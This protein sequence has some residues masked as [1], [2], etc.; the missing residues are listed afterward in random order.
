VNATI[1]WRAVS[2]LIETSCSAPAVSVAIG[3]SMTTCLPAR[4][5]LAAMATCEAF[6]VQMCTTSMSGSSSRPS[7][8]AVDRGTPS[9]AAFAAVRFESVPASATTSAYPVRRIAST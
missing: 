8:S 1:A 9:A 6:G 3:F 2:R 7:A 4:I 5:A